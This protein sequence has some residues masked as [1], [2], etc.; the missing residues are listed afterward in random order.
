MESNV[1]HHPTIYSDSTDNQEGKSDGN[2]LNFTPEQ[3]AQ[4]ITVELMK[5]LMGLRPEKKDA[6]DQTISAGAV[7]RG[8]GHHTQSS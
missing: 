5:K 4:P 6:S 7:V 8:S 1:C 3:L 2:L